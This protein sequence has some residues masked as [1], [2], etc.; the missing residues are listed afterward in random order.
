M[1]G[2]EIGK[3]PTYVE[4]RKNIVGIRVTIMGRAT[5]RIVIPGSCLGAVFKYFWS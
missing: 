5:E 4:T 3:F 2:L 1:V